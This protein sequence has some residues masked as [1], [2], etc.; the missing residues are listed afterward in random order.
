MPAARFGATSRKT[1]EVRSHGFAHQRLFRCAWAS[2]YSGTLIFAS[3]GRSCP[4]DWRLSTPVSH[5][6]S[7]GFDEIH[8]VLRVESDGDGVAVVGY[9]D[10]IF[11]LAGFGGGCGNFQLAFSRRR[12]TARERSSA[13]WA[14]RAMAAPSSS[15]CRA[16]DLVM[17]LGSTASY[18]GIGR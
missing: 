7:R 17:S 16:M 2:R 18:W 5:R 6:R 8:Q 10:G 13:N 15:P 3:A 11:G 9:F 4:A 14:T 12:R 1:R